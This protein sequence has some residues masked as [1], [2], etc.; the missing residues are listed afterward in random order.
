MNTNNWAIKRLQYLEEIYKLRDCKCSSGLS[1]AVSE[2]SGAAS[3]SS[4]AA[5]SLSGA[6]LGGSEWTGSAY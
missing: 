2:L 1:G 3:G 6:H 5:L 4:G